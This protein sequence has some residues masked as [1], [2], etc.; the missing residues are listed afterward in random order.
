MAFLLYFDSFHPCTFLRSA[1]IQDSRQDSR[2]QIERGC[3]CSTIYRWMLKL[4]SLVSHLIS[5]SSGRWC[6]CCTVICSALLHSP[7]K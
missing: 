7:I 4:H 3:S 5:A 1:S 6:S 2:Q